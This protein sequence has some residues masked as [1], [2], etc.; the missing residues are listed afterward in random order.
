M[1][2]EAIIFT[3]PDMRPNVPR[4]LIAAFAETFGRAQDGGLCA[5]PC[6]AADPAKP[7]EQCILTC[8]DCADGW[9]ATGITATRRVGSNEELV[10]KMMA[11]C[12]TACRAYAQACQQAGGNVGGRP[13]E[14]VM[15]EWPVGD[16]ADAPVQGRFLT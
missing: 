3:R 5:Q 8:L 16:N 11:V 2:A 7:M 12:A 4:N 13:T 15:D 10:A 9:L 1:R 14:A 6:L